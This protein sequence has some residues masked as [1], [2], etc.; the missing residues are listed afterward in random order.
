[1]KR[2]HPDGIVCRCSPEGV[3]SRRKRH[4]PRGA[5][6]TTSRRPAHPN[7]SI[8]RAAE[9]GSRYRFIRRPRST[10]RCRSDS[11]SL[12]PSTPRIRGRLEDRHR[13]P[14]EA[15]SANEMTMTAFCDASAGGRGGAP[16]CCFRSDGATI[17]LVS[18]PSS[19]MFAERCRDSSRTR[20]WPRAAR[21]SQPSCRGRASG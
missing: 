12:R 14:D 1:M 11:A 20:S 10:R 19:S 6:S 9:E 5:N 16:L 2:Q 8:A 7:D 21:C 18:V 4:A 3:I 17:S 15:C 13:R